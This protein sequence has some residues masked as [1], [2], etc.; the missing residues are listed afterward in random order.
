M[1]NRP[2]P[3]IVVA[4]LFII[5]GCVGLLYHA[6]EYI[7]RSAVKYELVWVLFIRVLAIVCGELLL[8]RINWGRWLSI[9]WLAYHVVLSLFH[10]VSET[11]AHIVLL[12]IVSFLLFI[13]RSSAY[14]RSADKQAGQK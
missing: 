3:V 14:F 5:A 6:N 9:A 1:K 7:E 11:V 2:L 12:I 10:S 13:P 8:K 4:L